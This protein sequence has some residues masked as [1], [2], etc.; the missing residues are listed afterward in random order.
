MYSYSQK[1]LKAAWLNREAY[2]GYF[3][4]SARLYARS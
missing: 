2:L 4:A 1:G 3:Y